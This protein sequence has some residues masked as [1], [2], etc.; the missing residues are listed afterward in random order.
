MIAD[1]HL[2]LKETLL[3]KRR[4]KKNIMWGFGFKFL[5]ESLVFF[6]RKNDKKRYKKLKKKKHLLEKM[7]CADCFFLYCV[8]A[9]YLP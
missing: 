5:A 2:I 1:S 4:E 8:M 9:T 6:S 3:P 7:S